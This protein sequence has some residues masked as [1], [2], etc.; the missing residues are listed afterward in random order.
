MES[1][2]RFPGY[3]G[4]SGGG[5][6]YVRQWSSQSAHGG[7]GG[8]G[9]S[10]S[11]FHS[12]NRFGGFK[13]GPQYQVCTEVRGNDGGLTFG[14]EKTTMQNLNDRL[15]S[16]LETVRNLEQANGKLELKIREA[17]EKRGPDTNDYS[18]YNVILDDL[19][20]KILEMISANEQ[21]SIQGE[22]ARL[23]AE[24]FRV[25]FE[26]EAGM[27]QTVEADVASLKRILDDTNVVRLHLENDVESLKEELVHLKK[28]HAVDVLELRTQIST[29]G[30]NVEVDA[31]RGQDL[32]KIMEDMRA[33]YEA[34]AL[35]NQEDVKM[36]HESKIGEVQIQVAENTVAL[37]EAHTT[38]SESRRS[39]QSLQIE[40]QSQIRLKGSLEGTLG[41][42]DMR[43][44]MEMEKYNNILLRLE[45]E[46]THIR[47]N[48]QKQTQDYQV[49]F[50]IKTRLEAEIAEYRRLLD[51]DLIVEV[52]VEKKPTKSYQTKTMVVTQTLVDGKIVS[53]EATEA[54]R[55]GGAILRNS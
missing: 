2:G 3:L 12:G 44:N 39:V 13:G 40:L 21:I 34:L 19:R 11:S 49:L 25:K 1:L 16:Y 6:R 47:S 50:N 27:C 17:M 36:W 9:T 7:A 18:R 46:L 37:K 26:S 14:N 51:G 41:E 35:K 32:G 23:A 10:T 42:I 38:V 28:N 53:E 31:A 45:A 33:K 22:N 29:A 54:V 30:V 24:D 52:P 20:K 4:E 48:I 5:G 55:P 43:N 8:R 15:A